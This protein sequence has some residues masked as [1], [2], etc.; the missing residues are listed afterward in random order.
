MLIL[1]TDCREICTLIVIVNVFW[2][3]GF[4]KIHIILI[5]ICTSLHNLQ[6]V[7]VTWGQQESSVQKTRIKSPSPSSARIYRPSFELVFA[8]T[9]SIN[10]G[11]GKFMKD[12]ARQGTVWSAQ[13]RLQYINISKT[14]Q[15]CMCLKILPLKGFCRKF[16]LEWAPRPSFHR[17]PTPKSPPPCQT[18]VD[19]CVSL[20]LSISH[21]NF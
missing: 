19:L 21:C 18:F 17:R 4:W 15:K 8:K 2:N 7:G 10:S 13:Q 12:K 20:N 5:L 9:G 14:I 3:T 1:K 11:T 16:V 6:T